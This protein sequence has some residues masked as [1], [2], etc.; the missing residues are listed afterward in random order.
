MQ[1]PK[2][3]TRASSRTSKSCQNENPVAAPHSRR[4]TRTSSRLSSLYQDPEDSSIICLDTSSPAQLLS[5]EPSQS[6]VMSPPSSMD[7]ILHS[8]RPLKS[9]VLVFTPMISPTPYEPSNFKPICIVGVQVPDCVMKL[10]S[11]SP[12]TPNKSQPPDGNI[13]HAHFRYKDF[14]ASSS[15]EDFVNMEFANF[16]KSSWY[17]KSSKVPPAL[18]NLMERQSSFQN[19][20]LLPIQIRQNLLS[21]PG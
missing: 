18:P 8:Q 10:A 20:S 3:V 4:V 6:S 7:N 11:I 5:V 16:Q 21:W 12:S 9:D 19:W 17:E 1:V 13:L 15:F 14:K 2:R